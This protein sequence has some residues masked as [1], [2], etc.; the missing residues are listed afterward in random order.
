[1]EYETVRD[2]VLIGP[3]GQTLDCLALT[4]SEARDSNLELECEGRGTLYQWVLC[5]ERKAA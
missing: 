2:Y 1:M 5:E 3:G 4:A